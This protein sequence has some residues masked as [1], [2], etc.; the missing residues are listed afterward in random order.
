MRSRAAA[1]LPVQRSPPPPPGD[2]DP[3]ADPG[4]GRGRV[5]LSHTSGT[6]PA[7][8]RLADI[9]VRSFAG[10][11]VDCIKAPESPGDATRVAGLLHWLA[12]APDRADEYAKN[13]I[14]GE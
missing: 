1:W 10:D 5:D 2:A 14:A 4:R 12:L 9:R 6:R 13:G 8:P 3:A 11:A 7:Q